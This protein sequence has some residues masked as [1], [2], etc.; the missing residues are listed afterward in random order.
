[1][2]IR[3]RALTYE[4]IL[5]IPKYSE[6]LPKNVN[7]STKLTKKITMN[8]PI[9][10]AAMDT[11]TQHK[12]A[13][14]MARLGGL[15][16]VHKN[17][18]IEEQRKEI[19]LVKKSESGVIFDPVFAY[20]D[21]SLLSAKNTM[22]TFRI[23][24]VPIIDKDKK[25]IGILTN[26]DLRF[27]TDFNK[28]I[29]DVM[30]S[31][32][33]ITAKIGT[34][35]DEAKVILHKHKIEKLPLVDENGKLD[36]L[37]T[38]KDIN[39]KQEF[40]NANTDD[41][42]RLKVGAAIGT[43]DIDRARALCKEGVDVL[44]L[45]SAHGD[46]KGI[47]DTLKEIKKSFDVEVIA[48]NIATKEGAK[49]LCEAGADAIKVGIGPGSICTTRIISGIGV[50]QGSAVDVCVKVANEY[51]V[52]V[53]ADGG[54]KSS[55]DTFVRHLNPFQALSESIIQTWR[56]SKLVVISIVKILQGTISVK[57]IGGPIMIAEM[58]GQQAREGA[59]NFIFFIA[60]LSVNL[61]VLNILP[62]P[63]LDGGHLIFFFIEAAT[64]HPVSIKVREIAQQAGIVILILL[65]IFVFYNDIARIFFS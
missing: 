44:V 46:S 12:M 17:M 39:K 11:V 15:G 32:N 38:T 29:K 54:I 65:M 62:I 26:R 51:G 63:V 23:S 24:G 40:P 14:M 57:N 50:P 37:I 33:L 22:D 28:E 5:L 56:I 19:N 41:L 35:L 1:M 36:G 20:I 10:S 16:V 55:G 42:G 13:I 30:T 58:A 8:M 25:L 45:D 9:I 7:I 49:A 47:I 2:K 3:M 21:D 59:V 61:G 64:G 4:D 48:G 6:I 31:E 52:P 27:E 53:I 18:S 34:S 60:L 43:N